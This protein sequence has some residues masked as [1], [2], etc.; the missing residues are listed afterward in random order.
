VELKKIHFR[1]NAE[2]Q[3]YRR[4]PAS[5][6]VDIQELCDL[7]W[8]GVWSLCRSAHGANPMTEFTCFDFRRL[9]K[10]HQLNA[11]TSDMTDFVCADFVCLAS[12]IAF[13]QPTQN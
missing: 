2:G 6:L 8:H 10:I 5:F 7:R 11:L 3:T 4:L 1:L 13:S 9:P 12:T